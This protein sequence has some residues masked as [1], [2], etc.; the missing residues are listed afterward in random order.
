MCSS[1]I[2]CNLICK[3]YQIR[4]ICAKGT[5]CIALVY[6][7]PIYANCDSHTGWRIDRANRKLPLFLHRRYFGEA[8]RRN[9]W[10]RK[11]W[12]RRI[13][14]AILGRVRTKTRS[15]E[16]I[17]SSSRLI[18]RVISKEDGIRKRRRPIESDRKRRYDS[19]VNRRV[20]GL[21]RGS[22]WEET[23]IHLRETLPE[24]SYTACNEQAEKQ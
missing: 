10:D 14:R 15:D 2:T 6:A 18:P 4:L 7:G 1:K 5:F 23:H 9:G 11:N 22:E 17:P 12:F 19:T 24:H 13:L 16:C 21:K 20:K 8:R 3:T